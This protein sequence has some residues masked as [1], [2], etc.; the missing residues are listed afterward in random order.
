MKKIIGLTAVLM[1]VMILGGCGAAQTNQPGSANPASP[2]GSNATGT[3]SAAT[4]IAPANID[5]AG[6]AFSPKTLT[7]KKGTVVIWTNNDS[8]S[9]KIKSDTFNSDVLTPGQSFPFTFNNTGTF[10]YGC[11]IH[12]SMT[13]KIIVE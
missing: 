12:P 2:A 5:I 7:V 9:H 1:S 11:A 3:P 6:F 13:G 4:A 8:V 10:D